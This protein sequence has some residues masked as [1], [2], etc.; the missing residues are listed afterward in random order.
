MIS[1]HKLRMGIFGEGGTGKSRLIAAICAWFKSS[2]REDDLLIAA[3]TGSA[4]RKIS[5]TTV[6]SA[7]GISVEDEDPTRM[8]PVN[9]AKLAEWRDRNYMVTA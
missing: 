7:A 2:H 1:F 4:A 8:Q 5:G 3:S 9:P 6:H